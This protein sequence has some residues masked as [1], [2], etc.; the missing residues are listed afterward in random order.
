MDMLK[1]AFRAP[2]MTPLLYTMDRIAREQ[3]DLGLEISTIVNS[4]EARR[5]LVEGKIDW[6][7]GNHY[8]V[9]LG[10]AHGEKLSYLASTENIMID[11]IVTRED[12]QSVDHFISLVPGQKVAVLGEAWD[13]PALNCW[14]WLRNHGI[15]DKVKIVA[16]AE[17]DL[18]GKPLFEGHAG[19]SP[20]CHAFHSWGNRAIRMVRD[21]EVLAAFIPPNAMLD[22]LH[23]GGF[24]V[25]RIEPM[26]MVEGLTVTTST[27][28]VVEKRELFR[29]MLRALV[30]AIR[31]MKEHKEE[32]LRTIEGEPSKYLDIQSPDQALSY[33]NFYMKWRTPID[34]PYPT[35]E[36]VKNAHTIASRDNPE[37]RKINPMEVW[38]LHFLKEIDAEGLMPPV[39]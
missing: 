39:G 30:K 34:R 25:H 38:D 4:R 15:D 22:Y 11:A 27:A 26:P 31:Y 5:T 19:T 14:L 28:K 33:Y 29:R 12:V 36:A 23:L 37:V 7:G 1:V 16:V 6:I 9:Y 20:D 18:P 21:K 32:T 2:I 24:K 35:L 3:Y 10:W 8:D 17:R 13:H